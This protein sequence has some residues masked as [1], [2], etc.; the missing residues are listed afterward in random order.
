MADDEDAELGG[1][2]TG[3]V[4]EIPLCDDPT[5]QVCNEYED[6]EDPTP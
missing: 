2:G 3:G 4:V 1:D 5:D 6:N